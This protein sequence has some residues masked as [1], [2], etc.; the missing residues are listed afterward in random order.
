[1]LDLHNCTC[2]NAVK[3][4]P[5]YT[6]ACRDSHP[7]RH[8]HAKK[9]KHFKTPGMSKSDTPGT[10]LHACPHCI[11]R[12]YIFVYLIKFHLIINVFLKILIVVNYVDN[13]K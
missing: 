8:R 2:I 11:G 6:E 5:K 9:H 12:E 4:M 7:F 3:K 10:I 1:M 13:L